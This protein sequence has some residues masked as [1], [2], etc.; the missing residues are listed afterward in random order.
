MAKI[1]DI[2]FFY[3][4]VYIAQK[5]EASVTA[6]LQE[7]I[8]KYE[9]IFLEG[10][11]GRELY[12]LF[13]AWLDAQVPGD[14]FDLILRGAEFTYGSPRNWEGLKV[15]V[16][17][18]PDK[19]RSIIA[20]YVYCQWMRDKITESTGSG[21]KILEGQNSI[22]VSVNEKLVTVWNEMATSCRDLVRFLES[23]SVAYPEFNRLYIKY[24]LVKFMNPLSF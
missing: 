20:N 3:G 5:S 12:K 4:N 8:N 16:N 9:P 7:Y 23:D 1:I 22:S 2:S 19:F 10:I 24:G 13:Y 6:L 18:A 21:E 14:R 15:Q 17:T 11:L